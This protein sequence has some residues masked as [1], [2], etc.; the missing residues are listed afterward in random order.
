LGHFERLGI[1]SKPKEREEI[2]STLGNLTLIIIRF[3][4]FLQWYYVAAVVNLAARFLW[5]LTI[6]P[7]SIGIFLNPIIFSSIL[8]GLEIARRAIWNL[9]RMENEQLTNV[10]KFRVVKEVPPVHLT[11]EAKMER[12]TS[13]QFVELP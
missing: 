13:S 8:A 10:G 9:F 6:S 12:L 1:A 7:E 5:T 4:H 3:V 2:V 11:V